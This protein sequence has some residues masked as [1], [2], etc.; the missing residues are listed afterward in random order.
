MSAWTNNEACG[1]PIEFERLFEWVRLDASLIRNNIPGVENH[2]RS[3]RTQGETEH[4]LNELHHWRHS[5]AFTE[6]EKAALNLTETISLRQSDAES[7]IILK[8]ARIHFTTEEIVRLSL[9]IMAVN[10][11]IDLREKSSIRILVVEDNPDD[12]EYLRHQLRKIQMDQN[13]LFVTDAHQALDFIE[14][15]KKT[16]RF[17]LI[18]IFLDIHLPGINGVELLQRIRGIPGMKNFPVIMVTASDDPRNIE[19]CKKLNVLSYVQKPITLH[20]F[21]KA[22]ANLFHPARQSEA[23]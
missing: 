1:P 2:L 20:S 9:N 12:Q 14:E 23:A 6:R 13:V 7:T 21:R 10:D 17:E 3:L 4:R 8:D 11:W 18:A 16:A 19:E 15:S 5:S 22:I